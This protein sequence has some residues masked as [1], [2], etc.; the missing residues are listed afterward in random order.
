MGNI[1]FVIGIKKKLR[2]IVRSIYL[3]FDSKITD[4]DMDFLQIYKLPNQKIRIGKDNDGGYVILDGFSYDLLIGCGISDD[5]S[6]ETQF[7]HKYGVHCYAFD[8]TIEKMPDPDP[9]ITFVRKNISNKN[10]KKKTNLHDLISKHKNI[11]LK[12][13]IECGEYPWFKSLS[14]DQLCK[15]QQIVIE[16][17]NPSLRFRWKH[18]KKLMDTHY[19]C[20]LHPNNCCGPRIIS[21]IKV[22]C[23]FECT[24]IRKAGLQHPPPLSDE[25]IPGELDMK[26]APENDDICLTGYPYTTKEK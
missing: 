14:R 18:I 1:F 3:F 21:G 16:L 2:K 9:N 8:G 15:F 4:F 24:F 12:M 7:T 11:F 5:N 17:H 19:L 6:F 23:L 25:S 13:D 22:P 20:H 26:N 10:N